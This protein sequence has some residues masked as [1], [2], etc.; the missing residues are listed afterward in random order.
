MSI[1]PF[2]FI[3]SVSHGTLRPEDLI[4]TF[5]ELLE[6]LN[7]DSYS[8]F[9]T[10]NTYLFA[11]FEEMHTYICLGGQLYDSDWLEGEVNELIDR[12]SELAPPYFYFGAH[13]GDGSDFGFWF[14]QHGFDQARQD[15]EIYVSNDSPDW[16]FIRDNLGEWTGTHYV[17][18]VNDHG[19]VTLY[20]LEGNEIWAIV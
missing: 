4:P 17:A 20:D 14:D 8:E 5:A 19:N 12:L 15:G 11:D 6:Q 1:K 3:G 16:Q 7:S 10:D 2:R 13:E 9:V 18:V